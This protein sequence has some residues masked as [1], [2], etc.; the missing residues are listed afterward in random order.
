VCKTEEEA[1]RRLS[2][3]AAACQPDPRR[4]LPRPV[5]EPMHTEKA[6]AKPKQPPP[7]PVLEPTSSDKPLKHYGQRVF[8]QVT[9]DEYIELRAEQDM[10]TELGI[11]WQ[12]RGPPGPADGGPQTWRGQAFRPLA[13][14]WGNRGGQHREYYRALY[15]SKGVG[16]TGKVKGKGKVESLGLGVSGAAPVYTFGTG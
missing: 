16:A 6:K 12:N 14:K 7:E 9:M 15:S 2:L 4:G 5:L 11:R 8:R 10:A 1:E 13:N 3:Q